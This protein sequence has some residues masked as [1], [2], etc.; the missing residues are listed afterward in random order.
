MILPSITDHDIEMLLDERRFVILEGPPGTGKTRLAEILLKE[1]YKGNGLTIQFHPNTTYENFVGGLS[2]EEKNDGLGFSFKPK[3]G[4]FMEAITKAKENPEKK[5]LLHIDEINRADLAKVLG[6]AIILIESNDNNSRHVKLPYNFL[7]PINDCLD[8]PNNLHIIG[9]MNSSDRSIAIL[10]IAIRRRFA[11]V[12]LWPQID[13][14]NSSSCDLMKK[15]FQGLLLVFIEYTNDDS[16]NLL[17]GHAYF[18]EKDETKAKRLLK[19][20]LLPLLFEYL[21]QGYV[22]SFSEQILSY[23]QWLKSL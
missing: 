12:K 11:F 7:D 14:V 22:A 5:F 8:L 16:L 19:S 23:I 21:A 10:D 15:D 20:N 4:Y 2:P 3:R 9:T 17:P 1:K 6:E 13:V 18:L